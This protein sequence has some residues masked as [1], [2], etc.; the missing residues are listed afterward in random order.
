MTEKEMIDNARA[1]ITGQ[2]QK[3]QSPLATFIEEYVNSHLTSAEVAS[4]VSGKKLSDLMAKIKNHAKSIAKYGCAMVSDEEVRQMAD[5]FYGLKIE[6]KPEVD[7]HEKV[8][9]LDLL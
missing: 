1:E 9:V 7:T 4:K 2:S 5:E 8:D 6:E 3:E